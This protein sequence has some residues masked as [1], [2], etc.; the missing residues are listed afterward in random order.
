MNIDIESICD[1]SG[2]CTTIHQIH[3]NG[4]FVISKIDSSAAQ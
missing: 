1:G 2:M 3:A 4:V